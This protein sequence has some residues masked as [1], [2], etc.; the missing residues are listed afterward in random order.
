MGQ[1][2][3]LGIEV[4]GIKASNAQDHSDDIALARAFSHA[5]RCGDQETVGDFHARFNPLLMRRAMYRTQGDEEFAKD[6]V[7]TFWTS[8]VARDL[9]AGFRG[10]SKLTTFLI[11]I[12]DRKII[13][14]RRKHGREIIISDMESDEDGE[15][16]PDYHFI[17][18]L[19]QERLDMGD[20]FDSLQYRREGDL[21][22]GADEAVLQKRLQAMRKA[23]VALGERYPD[24]L[25]LVGMRLKGM[26]YQEIAPRLGRTVEAL[27]TAYLRALQRLRAEMETQQACNAHP[28]DTTVSVCHTKTGT[29]RFHSGLRKGA[30][31]AECGGT[32]GLRQD[33]PGQDDVVPGV[34]VLETA[35]HVSI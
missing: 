23:M 24:D 22:L 34:T 35:G 28:G 26:T 31:H 3:D 17:D 15:G 10:D 9:L 30:P 2:S 19:A 8:M 5:L 11:R 33:L 6:A 4:R 14:I 13:D 25:R 7:A 20:L 29:A 12:L 18:R 1:D 27:R 16:R 21:A 32:E